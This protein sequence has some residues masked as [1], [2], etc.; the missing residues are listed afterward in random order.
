MSVVII[1]TLG[2]GMF[3]TTYLC[4][5]DGKLFARKIQKILHTRETSPIWRE[6]DL[7]NYVD[8]LSSANKKFFMKLYAYRI[9]KDCKHKQSLAFKPRGKLAK[10]TTAL[11]KSKLGI[12]YDLSYVEGKTLAEFNTKLLTRDQILAFCLQIY[13]I[14][15]TLYEGGYF[16]NDTHSANIIVTKTTD[17]YFTVRGHKIPYYGYQLVLI[18]YGEVASTKFNYTATEKKGRYYNMFYDQEVYLFSEIFGAIFNFLD[19]FGRLIAEHRKR[20]LKMPFEKKTYDFGHVFK[21]I[22]KHTDFIE[23]IK[24]KYLK[25]IA[26]DQDHSIAVFEAVA[27][28]LTDPGDFF[29]TLDFKARKIASKA[30]IDKSVTKKNF[31]RFYGTIIS[32]FVLQNPALYKKYFGWCT[33]GKYLLNY[34][35]VEHLL[36][37]KDHKEMFNALMHLLKLQ[38][39]M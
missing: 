29:K 32:E 26:T 35:D 1:K 11:S 12:E 18:D 4:K 28:S 13:K 34:G 7:F 16:H 15:F 39:S 31:W 36:Y 14:V 20:K 24:A 5:S 37:V 33:T 9:I 30:G 27:S 10:L 17:V 2:N 25:H 38:H 6:I 19:P 23:E 3:G 8:S 22:I 21:R